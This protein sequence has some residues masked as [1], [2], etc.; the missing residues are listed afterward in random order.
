MERM[1]KIYRE[2]TW[3]LGQ[4][5]EVT[6]NKNTTMNDLANMVEKLYP[7]LLAANM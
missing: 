4:R 1:T 3:V 2:K 7:D 5:F 6:V